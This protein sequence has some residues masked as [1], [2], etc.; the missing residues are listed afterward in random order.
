M[1]K[2][3]FILFRINDPIVFPRACVCQYFGFSQ[4]PSCTRVITK[5]HLVK[6]TFCLFQNEV[7]NIFYLA[8]DE[9]LKKCKLS[10]GQVPIVCT[11]YCLVKCKLATCTRSLFFFQAAVLVYVSVET[12]MKFLIIINISPLD[13]CTYLGLDQ[14]GQACQVTVLV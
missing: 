1:Y 5:Q 8:S 9:E 7:D 2:S 14:G 4:L 12:A 6:N 3:R 13:S 11:V 10:D